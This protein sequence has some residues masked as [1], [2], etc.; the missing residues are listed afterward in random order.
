MQVFIYLIF[1][2]SIFIKY[3]SS[4]Y[5]QCTSHCPQLT[6]KFL[7]PLIIPIECQEN[8]NIRNIYDYALFCTIDYRIDYD[9]KEIYVNFKASN[10]THTF[11]QQNL[12]EFLIQTIWLGFNQESNQPNI[13]HRKYGCNT[14][15]D[16]ARSYYLNTIEYLITDGKLKL[17]EINLELYN[18]SKKSIHRCRDNNRVGNR[19]AVRCRNGLCYAHNI[20]GKQYCTSDNTPTLF[21][22]IEYYLPKFEENERELIEYKCNKHL[23]NRNETMEIIKNILL[24][25]TNWNTVENQIKEKSSTIQKAISYCLIILSLINLQFL[26]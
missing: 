23:C 3:S 12:S 26:F 7:Q 21:S 1:F 4:N 10:D 14:K 20:D 5:I 8:N 25:Y 18:Q 2:L 16:C 6:I 17:D 24:N 22:E 15:N 11:K 13:T 19:S 9:A